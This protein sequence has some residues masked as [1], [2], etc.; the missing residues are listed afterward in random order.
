[1][2]VHAYIVERADA[3]GLLH[4]AT[5][6][7]TDAALGHTPRVLLRM[8]ATIWLRD[9]AVWP[10]LDADEAAWLRAQEYPDLA[11]FWADT[12]RT[13]EVTLHVCTGSRDLFAADAP[14]RSAQA[15]SLIGFLADAEADGATIHWLG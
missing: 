11:T 7:L 3:A 12:L 15:D 9:P 2:T 6:L 5:R 10:A 1:M 8:G 13:A 4:L 14:A